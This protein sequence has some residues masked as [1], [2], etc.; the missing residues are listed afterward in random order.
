[1]ALQPGTT[2]LPSFAL[3][4]NLSV[5]G[6]SG[7]VGAAVHTG[8]VTFNGTVTLNG[9]TV[10]T[11]G[12]I[13]AGTI[14]AAAGTVTGLTSGYVGINSSGAGFAVQLPAPQKGA[15]FEIVNEQ[16]PGSGNHTIVIPAGGTITQGT[17]SGSIL[18]FN[19]IGQTA[20]LKGLSA[21]QY[22][23]MLPGTMNP[24]LS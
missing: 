13:Q 3:E 23:S 4:G 11:A 20:W 14:Y 10:N 2:N 15:N 17:V 16:T 7:F 19:K 5:G 12:G 24:T 8:P 1:M 6:T 9:P 22:F 18:T 21:T